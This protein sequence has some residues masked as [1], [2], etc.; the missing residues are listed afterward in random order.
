M[1]SITM[2]ALCVLDWVATSYY[3]LVTFYMKNES[4]AAGS[5]ETRLTFSLLVWLL[6]AS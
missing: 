2:S 5:V 1:V 3:M 4:F 6:A